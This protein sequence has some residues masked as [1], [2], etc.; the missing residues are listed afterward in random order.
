MSEQLNLLAGMKNGKYLQI[1]VS[2]PQYHLPGIIPEGCTLLVGP[3][4]IGKSWLLLSLAL[5]VASGGRV[6]GLS[7]DQRPVLYLALEDSDRRLQSRCCKLL[8]T[9]DDIPDVF[10]YLTRIEPGS[11]LE[12]V[13][14]A[15][16]QLPDGGPAPL[17]ILDTLGK[18]MPPAVIGESGYQR[19][20]QV[21]SALKHLVD[22]REGAALVI[23]HHDRKADAD[24]FVDAVS[25]SHGLAGS[26]DTIVVLARARQGEQRAAE[27]DW[28]GRARRRV[29]GH[30]QSGLDVGTRR[31]LAD[32]SGRQGRQGSRH[33]GCRRPH[34]RDH[35][36]RVRPPS[37][38]H[39]CPDR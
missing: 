27:G 12:T 14:L 28:Q 7:V 10:A 3:P 24:D 29:R 21:G 34:G 30:S 38:R 6:L 11:V 19:D 33:E 1:R 35:R 23:A 32:G 15:L 13:A 8:G 5:G 37:G 9:K 2:R 18:V 17:V 4:K 26:A 31:S 16:D 25:G 22:D 36:L 39:P 20:Y